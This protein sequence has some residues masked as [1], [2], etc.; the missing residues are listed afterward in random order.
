MIPELVD[1][2]VASALEGIKNLVEGAK[3]ELSVVAVVVNVTKL[4]D[5]LVGELRKRY[6]ALGAE[7]VEVAVLHLGVKDPKSAISALVEV[8]LDHIRAVANCDLVSSHSVAGDVTSAL[9]AVCGNDDALGSVF[10][11]IECHFKI[12]LLC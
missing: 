1:V 5:L 10:H 11:K 9:A 12:L 8:N 4:A 6:L 3:T 2:Y 7:I